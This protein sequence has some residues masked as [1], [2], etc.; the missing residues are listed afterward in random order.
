MDDFDKIIKHEELVDKIEAFIDTEIRPFIQ[1]DGGDIELRGFDPNTGV[2]RVSLMG[3]CSTCPSSV[4]TLR[5][6]VELRLREAF[7]EIKSLELA[8]LLDSL[9]S[10]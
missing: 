4:M 2:I 8:G 5:F 6:G 7:P 9:E 1:Q 3:A 10:L